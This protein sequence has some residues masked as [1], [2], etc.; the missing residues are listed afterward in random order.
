MGKPCKNEARC[1]LCGGPAR[2]RNVR[3]GAA[4]DNEVTE[5]AEN[6]KVKWVA[7]WSS[8]D[9]FALQSWACSR[10]SRSRSGRSSDRSSQTSWRAETNSAQ[11]SSSC[12]SVCVCVCVCVVC[13]RACVRARCVCGVRECLVCVLCIVALNNCPPTARGVILSDLLSVA[14][15]HQVERDDG[16]RYFDSRDE[17]RCNWMMFVRP[18][19][20]W[21]E[22]NLVAYQ[23][24][25][26]VYFTTVKPVD[27]KQELKVSVPR[28]RANSSV[29][30][31]H[32]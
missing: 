13:V 17:N 30:R 25:G 4:S 1:V 3:T 2:V 7:L 16:T 8:V 23:F 19:P 11:T 18:A 15:S 20:S 24:R 12:R 22:Q 26:D 5:A 14:V 32:V 10:R 9:V 27:A 29:T 31:S 21:A 6:V 28:S